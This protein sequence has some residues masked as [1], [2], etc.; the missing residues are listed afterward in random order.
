MGF[1]P[2]LNTQPKP[3]EKPFNVSEFVKGIERN[4]DTEMLIAIQ[5][6]CEAKGLDPWDNAEYRRLMDEGKKKAHDHQAWRAKEFNKLIGDLTQPMCPK[7]LNKGYIMSVRGTE[8]IAN[9]CS[10]LLRREDNG[11]N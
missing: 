10:C 5:K 1:I 4:R 8:L 6:A 3:L 7:C 9:K 11:R 2:N